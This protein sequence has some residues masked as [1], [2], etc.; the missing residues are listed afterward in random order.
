MKQVTAYFLASLCVG[1]GLV[2]AEESRSARADL[3]PPADNL[4][5]RQ[6]LDEAL[7]AVDAADIPMVQGGLIGTLARAGEVNEAIRIA[8]AVRVRNDDMEAIAVAQGQAGDINGALQTARGI[9]NDHDKGRALAQLAGIQADRGEFKGA[10]ETARAIA[11]VSGR[12]WAQALIAE[13]QAKAGKIQVA[14]DTVKTMNA[15]NIGSMKANALSAIALAQVRSGDVN[16]AVQTAKLAPGMYGGLVL[17]Q[18]ADA[19][20]DK[21]NATISEDL[22]RQALERVRSADPRTRGFVL[23][24]VASAQMKLGHRDA[25]RKTFHQALEAIDLW[26][27]RLIVQR[28][29]QGG[30]VEGALEN[31]RRLSKVPQAQSLESIAIVQAQSG[32][33]REALVTVQAIEPPEIRATALAQ[34]A[35]EQK[36]AGDI[37]GAT[38]TFEKAVRIAHL[39][40]PGLFDQVVARPLYAIARS[41]ARAGDAGT[42]L[43]WARREKSDRVR[44]SAFVGIAEGMLER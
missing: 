20:A 24:V 10:A 3:A 22:L 12:A 27:Q 39:S 4:S 13:G 23:G 42:A 33:F 38:D 1:I 32:H 8:R 21:G 19:C 30:D 5:A 36:R 40:A 44:A 9:P 6:V 35:G 7:T 28:Q 41:Q 11:D 34:V 17:A 43:Q 25:A 18:I 26:N 14:L 2:R 15:P 29:A 37:A 31:A 16:A